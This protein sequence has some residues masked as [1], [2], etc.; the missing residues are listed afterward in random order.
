MVFSGAGFLERMH[1][2]RGYQ[3]NYVLE[4]LWAA[5]VDLTIA[6]LIFLSLSGLWM[7]WELRVTRKLGA[8][9]LGAGLALF[10]LLLAVL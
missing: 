5:S 7:A 8:L 9:A 10:G 3:H 1:R 4:D 6:A 2:R